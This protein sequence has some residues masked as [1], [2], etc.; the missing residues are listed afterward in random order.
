[1]RR[2]FGPRRIRGPRDFQLAGN[3]PFESIIVKL[4]QTAQ[5]C[6]ATGNVVTFSTGYGTP[7][8]AWAAVATHM[9]T[10]PDHINCSIAASL[11]YAS[12]L[13]SLSFGSLAATLSIPFNLFFVIASR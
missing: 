12:L 7:L 1:M 4:R 11:I 6:S 8:L 2:N 5:V 3:G 10:Y 13:H 9:D